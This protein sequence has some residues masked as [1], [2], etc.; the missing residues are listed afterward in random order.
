[1][2]YIKRIDIRGFK[3]FAKKVSVSLDRG[4]TVITGPN[5]SG[6]S[7]ILDG[8]KF[9]L[10]ELS[11]KELRGRSLS[12]LVHKSQDEGAHSA[13]VAVQFDNSDRKIP[14]DSDQ[15]TISREFSRGGEGIYRLNGRRLSRKQVQDI[16]SSADIQVTGFNL[17]AQHAITRLAEIGTEERRKILEDLIGIGVFETKKAEAK[18][19]LQAADVNLRVA[20]AKVDEVRQRIEQLES[21]RND[22]LRY[23]LLRK[24]V[25][26]QQARIVSGQVATLEAKRDSALKSLEEQTQQLDKIREERDNLTQRRAKV[27]AERRRFEEKTVTKGNQELFEIERHIA[28]TSTEIVKAKT[29]AEALRALL[30]TRIRQRDSLL[31]EGEGLEANTKLLIKSVQSL[32]TRKAELVE[33][34]TESATHAEGLAEER[35]KLGDGLAPDMRK[36][37][38]L[39]EEINTLS[40]E[41]DRIIASSKGSLTKLDLTA[42]HLQTLQNRQ[43]EFAHLTDELRRRIREMERLEKE[44]EKRLQNIQGKVE[45]YAL[46]KSDRKNQ[47][48]EALGVAKKARVSV[49]EFNTQRDLAENL[50]AE[51]RA[52]KKIEEMADEGALKGVVGRLKD[53]VRFSEEYSKAIEA[54]SAG[55]MSALVVKNL[56][57]AIKCVESLK[58]TKLG[59]VKIIPLENIEIDE[60]N[61]NLGNSAG[62]VG[63]LSS[64]I[65]SDKAIAPAVEFVFGDTLLATNQRT[66]FLSAA[67]GQRCVATSGDLYEPG[68]GLESGYYRAPFDIS[69]LVPRTAVIEGLEKTLKS[70]ESII[71]KQGSDVDHLE[72]EIDKLRE[73]RV[74]STNTRETLNREIE[75]SKRSLERTREALQITKRRTDSL[76]ASVE[77]EKQSLDEM[78]G[79]QAEMKRRLSRLEE[80]RT[81]LKIDV[82]RRS[83]TELEGER[84]R[85]MSQANTLLREKLQVESYLASQKSTLETL[86]PNH[87]QIDIQLRS[88]NSEIRKEGTR[89]R[90]TTE[91][92]EDLQMRMKELEAQ[93][94]RIVESLTSLGAE[95]QK[96]EAQFAEMESALRSLLEKMDPLNTSMADLKGTLREAEARL[97]MFRSQLESTGYHAPLQISPDTAREAVELKEV[98]QKELDEIGAVN[99]LAVQQYEHQKDGYKQLSVRINE[100]EREKL[101]ILEFMNELERRKRD[102]FM[103]AFSKVNHT[104]QELFSQMTNGAGSGRMVLDNPDNPFEAGLDVML[105]FPG[106][107]ELTMGSA[108][109]GEK[110]VATVCYLLALQQIHPMPF[111]V[112]DE[113]DAH[114]DIVN[115]KRLATL[116]RSRSKGSQFIVISL[117]DTT[118]SKAERVYGVYNENG[119]SQVVSLP[120][121]GELS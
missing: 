68:G 45:Q 103:D 58:R 72:A 18:E 64:V 83:L 98:L 32:A 81:K 61:S 94:A 1:M 2:V 40:R 77:R 95:R 34:Y 19:Q 110:S 107:P 57:V 31:K 49:V 46:L 108:S 6:K 116:V 44:E 62:I 101:A 55:W 35:K 23:N 66:A 109:G 47:I 4:F 25:N 15:V 27:E 93:K 80:E 112:M 99:Q 69:N 41:I 39:H 63:T 65:R 102:V 10:G 56:S 87:D 70:L 60:V 86:K 117:K 50:Q 42:G 84:D 100:L 8:L 7:N 118:I 43:Q 121:R 38:E 21:E 14:V 115:T 17:I 114:L 79:K 113:I 52:I 88:L 119:A 53:L 76:L 11:P 106:K 120:V 75:T 90:E 33:K 78:A 20:T 54:A 48:E 59:R 22:L 37:E 96:Y 29:E 92:S 28:E 82:R 26:D 91:R 104:F 24:E 16:L 73:E 30:N 13:H 12:D 36:A 67:S 105:Q 9:A 74:S 3:T 97:S 89:V 71:E 111:Y 85:A 5:G 51:E